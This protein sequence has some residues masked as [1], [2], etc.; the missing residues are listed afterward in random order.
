MLKMV[1][2][3]VF[4]SFLIVAFVLV[5]LLGIFLMCC[6][7]VGKESEVSAMNYLKKE[8][9]PCYG[10]TERKSMC[11]AGCQKYKE[12][13]ENLQA[14]KDKMYE[15]NKAK[16]DIANYKKE[17]SRRFKYYKGRGRK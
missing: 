5:G 6:L 2:I 1:S 3:E 10:C 12:F 9:N 14:Q 7:I 13:K 15:E 17:K 11:H 4:I 8:N 16:Y